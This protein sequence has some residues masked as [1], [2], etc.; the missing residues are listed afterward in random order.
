MHCLTPIAALQL[1]EALG[2]A[3]YIAFLTFF[4]NVV[5]VITLFVGEYTQTL[6]LVATGLLLLF[7]I[8]S[9]LHEDNL[10]EYLKAGTLYLCRR[11]P[12]AG[13]QDV[14]RLFGLFH[15]LCHIPQRGTAGQHLHLLWK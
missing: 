11:K 13:G 5:N 7:N 12:G 3:A 6:V 4:P 15:A 1:K 2:Y 14:S 9:P 10:T 8:L